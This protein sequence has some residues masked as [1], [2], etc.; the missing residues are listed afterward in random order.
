[1][2]RN[3]LIMTLVMVFVLVT[4]SSIALAEETRYLCI[5]EKAVGFFF[6]KTSKQW[7]NTNF[8]AKNKYILIKSSDNKDWQLKTIEKSGK[9]PVMSCEGGFDEAGVI[10][11]EDFG[12]KFTMNNKNFKYIKVHPHGY[13]TTIIDRILL[14]S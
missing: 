4:F 5:P 8:N 2:K 9:Y 3:I 10:D 12:E 11:C 14:V 1:M 6:N 7:E 13:A